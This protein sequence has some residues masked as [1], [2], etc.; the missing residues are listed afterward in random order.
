MRERVSSPAQGWYWDSCGRRKG[1][2][3]FFLAYDSETLVF[4]ALT[5]EIITVLTD[6]IISHLTPVKSNL[7]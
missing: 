7:N 1:P 2:D 4:I 6:S 3:S 5:C